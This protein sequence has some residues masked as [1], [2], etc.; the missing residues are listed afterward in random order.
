M[1]CVHGMCSWY[2]VEIM[3]LM[4]MS[5]AVVS[6]SMLHIKT[7]LNW[8]YSWSNTKAIH[9]SIRDSQIII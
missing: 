5:A 3:K 2:I 9:V 8:L 1:V 7:H 6:G 4:T